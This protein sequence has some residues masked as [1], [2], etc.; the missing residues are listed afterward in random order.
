M[1]KKKTKC[2]G[3]LLEIHKR[4]NSIVVLA[5]CY[6]YVYICYINAEVMKKRKM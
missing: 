5:F 4:N 2:Q 3:G 6:F 1:N